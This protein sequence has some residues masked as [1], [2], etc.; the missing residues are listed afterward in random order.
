MKPGTL[1]FSDGIPLAGPP[2]P[3]HLLN[4]PPPGTF[5][6]TKKAQCELFDSCST[7]S[8]SS[9]SS[10]SPSSYL[11]SNTLINNSRNRANFGTLPKRKPATTTNHFSTSQFSQSLGKSSEP[12]SSCQALSLSCNGRARKS[13]LSPESPGDSTASSTGS[14]SGKTGL[15]CVDSLGHPAKKS[16]SFGV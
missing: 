7:S 12:S 9:C 11:S 14:G 2:L 5:P 4:G 16:G 6:R 10:S 1:S 3:Q 8:S 15:G 13:E